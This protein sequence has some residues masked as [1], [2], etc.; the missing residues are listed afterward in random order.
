M[1]VFAFYNYTHTYGYHSQFGAWVTAESCNNGLE[2]EEEEGCSEE[3][4]DGEES[5]PTYIH[6]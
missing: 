1:Y 5:T 4:S 2:W 3:I 6:S